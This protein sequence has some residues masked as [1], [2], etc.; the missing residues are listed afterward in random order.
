MVWALHVG[1]EARFLVKRG[2]IVLASGRLPS[3]LPLTI[4]VPVPVPTASAGLSG[5]SVDAGTAGVVM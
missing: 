4:P 5:P 1:G 3:A 2:G